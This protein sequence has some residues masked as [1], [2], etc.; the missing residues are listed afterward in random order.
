M[1]W[2]SESINSSTTMFVYKGIGKLVVN[3]ERNSIQVLVNDEL[4]NRVL[5]PEGIRQQTIQNHMESI[6]ASVDWL[7]ATGNVKSL[8]R[9]LEFA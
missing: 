5:F 4:K 7:I 8:E 9:E 3:E 1:N 2:V 6:E